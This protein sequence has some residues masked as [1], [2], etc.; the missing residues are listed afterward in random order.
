MR[1]FKNILGWVLPIVVALVLVT[2]IHATLFARANVDGDSMYPNL[3]NSEQ[4]IIW[5]Q[6]KIKPLSVIV[7]DAHGEAPDA[8][9]GQDYV[10]R[11]IGMPGDTVVSKKGNI[12]VNGKVLKQDFISKYQR[13]SGTGN[14]TLT[15]LSLNWLHNRG[16]VRV[17]NNEYFVLGDNRSISY[18]SRYWG[19]V[20]KDKVIGV[21]KT[22]PFG[23]N[24]QRSNN[25]NKLAI[26]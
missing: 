2:V 22:L 23:K 4:L 18:D 15:S 10:K 19:F 17:P 14:W 26:N 25:V 5:R 8:A 24:V 9:K 6:E 11:V 7:F 21:A 13:T 1:I 16:V 3:V 20:P 12:Y